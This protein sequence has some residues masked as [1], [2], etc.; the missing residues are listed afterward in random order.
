VCHHTWLWI[1]IF[2]IPNVLEW[3]LLV[4]ID[5][6]LHKFL[7]FKR[8]FLWSEVPAEFRR[9]HHIIWSWNSRQLVDL[10]FSAGAASTLSPQPL[11]CF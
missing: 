5:I 11:L 7:C 1:V 9:R 2:Y 4:L 8:L 10:G 6:M 3:W